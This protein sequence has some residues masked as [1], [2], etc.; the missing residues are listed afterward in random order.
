MLN[1]VKYYRDPRKLAV[2]ASWV[3][4][5]ISLTAGISWILAWDVIVSGFIAGYIPMMPP[6]ALFFFL[7]AITALM[8]NRQHEWKY[9]PHLAIFVSSVII[10]YSTYVFIKSI[11][12]PFSST[13]FISSPGKYLHLISPITAAAFILSAAAVIMT[14][15]KKPK[16]NEASV[17]LA[18]GVSTIGG[19]VLVSY[20]FGQPMLYGKNLIPM[21]IP[22]GFAF[23]LLGASL[24]FTVGSKSRIMRVLMGRDV[25]SQIIWAFTPATIITLLLTGWMEIYLEKFLGSSHT[26]TMTVVI[27]VLAS[28]MIVIISGIVSH[29]IGKPIEQAAKEREVTI[30]LLKLLNSSNDL[31]GL[32]KE[33]T[34]F[35]HNWSGCEAVGIRLKKGED[36]PY[37]ETSGFP[38]Q[39]VQLENSLCTYNLQGQ[40]ARDEAGN[41]VLDCM[42]GNIIQGRFDP[43]KP[44]FTE[45]GSFW[46]NCTT[47]L[48]ASTTEADR[49]AR[50]RNRC[51][52][53]GYESV[54]LIPLKT[55][56]ETFG[57]I[58]F[59]DKRKDVFTMEMIDLLER[60][61]DSIAIALSQR[62]TA[63]ELQ[64][65]EEHYRNL[66]ISMSDGF[67]L[68]EVIYDDTGEPC[69]YRYLETNPA[70][71]K[72]VGLSRNQIVGRTFKELVPEDTTKWLE[73]YCKVAK[74]GEPA[75][76]EFD[77]PEYQKTFETYSYQPNKGQVTVLVRDIS[78]RKR[79]EEALRES[80]EKYRAILEYSN[81]AICM[82]DN[83]GKIVWANDQMVTMGGYSKDQL[84]SA[85]SFAKFIA[86]ESLEFVTGNFLKVI[87]GEPYEHHYIF[88]IIRADGEKRQ[89]EKYMTHIRD[90]SGAIILVI[91]MMDITERKQM[92][93][94]LR[95]SEAKFRLLHETAGVGIG[96][97]DSQGNVISYNK[98]AAQNMNGKPEDFTGKSIFKLFP[99]PDCDI[100]FRRIKKALSESG[101]Q[102]YYDEVKL[103]GSTK[104][105]YSVFNR[106]VDSEENAIG[107]QIISSDISDRTNIEKEL[108]KS[109]ALLS[110][111]L[112]MAKLGHWE[113]DVP[114][115]MFTFTDEF[116]ELFGTT[117]EK[118]GGYLMPSSRY[119]E[120]FVHPDDRFMVGE[121]IR[122]L[123]ESS[124]PNYSRQVEHRIIRADGETGWI[125]VK[126][127][128]IKDKDGKT[129]KTYGANQDI[130]ERRKA[131]EALRESEAKYRS[132]FTEMMAGFAL[133][134]IVLDDKGVPFDYITVEVNSAY[135]SILG[136]KKEN[137]LGLKASSMLPPE[138]LKHWLKIF[139]GVALTG[140]STKYSMYSPL[141]K[142]YFEGVA[143]RPHA[144][145]FAVSFMDITERILSQEAL[146]ASEERLS[147]LI[148]NLP[149]FVYRCANDKNW[150]M[151]FISEGCRKIT[152]YA[153]EDFIGNKK[154]AYNDI[155]QPDYQEPLWKIWQELLPQ[156][157][158]FQEEYPIITAS[159]ETRWVWERGKGIYSETGS[160]LYLEGF[161]TDITELKKSQDA[162]LESERNLQ[163]L[164][165][166]IKESVALFEKSGTIIA[167]NE[168]F[169]ERL[170]LNIED[171]IGKNIFELIPKE[172]AVQRR[173]NVDE[174]IR[175]GKIVSF[176]DRR[177]DIWMYH[178]LCP[179][180]GS[181]GAVERMAV[182][183]M[184]ITERKKNEKALQKSEERYRYIIETAKEGIWT[185]DKDHLT[186][187]VNDCMAEMLGRKPED[188]IGRLVDEFMFDEDLPAHEERMKQRHSGHGGSY[189]HRFRRPD[190]SEIWTM[191]SAAAFKD[192]KGKFAG[193]FGMFTDITAKKHA[194]ESLMWELKVNHSMSDLAREM[195]SPGLNSEDIKKKIF[196]AALVLTNSK[197]GY[198]SELDEET[199]NMLISF[200]SEVKNKRDKIQNFF[201]EVDFHKDSDGNYPGILGYSLNTRK[202]FF[203]NDPENHPAFMKHAD[204]N[205]PLENFLSIPAVFA[206][207]L[208]GQISLANC[209]NGF[210]ERDRFIVQNLA[211]L[212]ALAVYRLRMEE[213]TRRYQNQLL[214]ADKMVSLGNLVSSLAHEINNPNFI[215]KLHTPILSKIWTDV[216]PILEEYAE[217]Q[218]DFALGETTFSSIRNMVP[219]LCTKIDDGSNRIK[220]IVDNLRMF[221]VDREPI[222]T[223]MVDVNEVIKSSIYLMGS[224]IKKSTDNFRFEQDETIP[225][226]KGNFQKL[227]QVIIN[228]LQN[229]CQALPNQKKGIFVTTKFDAANQRIVVTI[230]DEGEGIS[231]ENM[232]IIG[233]SFFTTKYK[234]GGTGLGLAISKEIIK[235]HGGTLILNSEEGIGTIVEIILP[236]NN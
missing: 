28:I 144:G 75:F 104:W 83:A 88:T 52:G 179:V 26:L 57:L 153:P 6:T 185:M 214:M 110:D 165:N 180:I 17:V 86:P 189:L 79:A 60:L 171:C 223:E 126:F 63:R 15:L 30:N 14:F 91:N 213:K 47:E 44:F 70:F 226:I 210:D 127:N 163:S 173:R 135:E 115:D 113:Y 22:T 166:A 175:T 116:Y 130:T 122:M 169:A 203:T 183:A 146:K 93:K 215:I 148:D 190:N 236:V 149:G 81:Y 120:L 80:E 101:T 5:V 217:K 43:S 85:E 94:A 65:S 89:F 234:K 233:K 187:Y 49:Q 84:L 20:W 112:R 66:F 39:F 27:T 205:I 107:V 31:H 164:F 7:L 62:K 221:A 181:D 204:K 128:I 230:R 150:T 36:F 147:N 192:E 12:I 182:Y 157:K 1:F 184:D 50:T 56:D 156:R 106:I 211:D 59:N 231:A 129:I 168:T 198:I 38:P 97:Y 220:N 9:K 34:T 10:I 158:T 225:K 71:E 218:G 176:E 41:P 45:H 131:E 111:A 109:K 61:G 2:L 227:D 119:A 3:L 118:M 133:H 202:G 199:G 229:A 114:T 76:F 67:Y 134:K 124:D 35:L 138:E 224:M 212:Y 11:S 64:E 74:T 206:E 53:M 73:T 98:T 195:L 99:K 191:V 77:S 207:E 102:E 216:M 68:S 123:L 21:S 90:R 51:N 82:V 193:S 78:E 13:S 219:E 32:I 108:K 72:I 105:F 55:T 48:L 8:L 42:C 40:L 58:Q 232:K 154:L 188:I 228:L 4:I 151:E 136:I 117:A 137:V 201:A 121:E 208:L 132:L 194:E 141:N 143:Y 197:N 54:A 200:A 139:G 159:G 209:E 170:K 33:L 222:P 172:I 95:E 29:K 160:L 125:L 96:Y 178:T 92:E 235:E 37:F 177:S 100:Y 18:F 196:D 16:W 103:P 161:I 155:V 167:A 152:G 174:V 162:L 25:R 140:K 145:F 23:I 87:A 24:M 19:V 186:T 142:K 46:S 69:D